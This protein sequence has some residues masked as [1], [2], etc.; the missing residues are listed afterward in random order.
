[1]QVV[2]SGITILAMTTLTCKIPEKLHAELEALA[3]RQRLSKS[4]VLRRALEKHLRQSSK[5]SGPR[6]FDLV[7][8]LCGTLRGPP[9]L[10][11]NPRHLEELGA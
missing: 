2:A 6:A 4:A 10:S 3:R 7:K 8:S 11:T 5:G 1:L 9:D